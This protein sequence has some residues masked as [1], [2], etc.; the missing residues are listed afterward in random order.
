VSKA[1]KASNIYLTKLFYL[2]SFRGCILADE[3]GLG[4][5]IQSISFMNYLMQREGIRG[6]FL[7]VAPLSTIGH[8]MREFEEWTHMNAVVYQG[9]YFEKSL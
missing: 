2:I 8:W 7:V 1:D 9:K 3:M 4:K 6:P 5:T